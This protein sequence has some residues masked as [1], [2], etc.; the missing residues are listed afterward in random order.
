MIEASRGISTK[1]KN[2]D[3]VRGGLDA[4][5]QGSGIRG[6]PQGGCGLSDLQTP[7]RKVAYEATVV[8]VTSSVECRRAKPSD[9]IRPF[10]SKK[11]WAIAVGSNSHRQPP[12]PR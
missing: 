12:A 4:E 9:S 7:Y 3:S 6:R 11:P 5:E 1:T 8:S 2:L 10:V